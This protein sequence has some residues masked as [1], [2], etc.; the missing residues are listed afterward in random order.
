MDNGYEAVRLTLVQ[1][2]SLVILDLQ[3]PVLVGW[4]V[5][6]ALRRRGHDVPILVITGGL[7]VARAAK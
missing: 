4:G 5:A 1:A 3:M 2:P 6:K 7:E